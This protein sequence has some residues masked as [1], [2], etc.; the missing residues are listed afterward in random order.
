V[1]EVKRWE[2]SIEETTSFDPTT[3]GLPADFVLTDWSKMK[4]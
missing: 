3:I 2:P 4:G 1:E